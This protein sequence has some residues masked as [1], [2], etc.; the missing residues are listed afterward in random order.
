[1]RGRP[2]FRGQGSGIRKECG[3][4]VTMWN[5]K[6]EAGIPPPF[7]MLAKAGIQ[8]G[9]RR[10]TGRVG[11]SASKHERTEKRIEY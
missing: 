9:F 1:M 10:P 3:A 7:V 2:E 8:K 6:R 4:I 5:I 11:F